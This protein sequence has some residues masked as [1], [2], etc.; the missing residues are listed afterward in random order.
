MKYFLTAVVLCILAVGCA[1][2]SPQNLPKNSLIIRNPTKYVVT[3][4]GSIFAK[5]IVINPHQTL[6]LADCSKLEKEQAELSFIA[7]DSFGKRCAL[8]TPYIGKYSMKVVLGADEPSKVVTLHR[9]R[10]N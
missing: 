7:V 6:S 5:P 4:N 8:I 1:T 2:Q 9:Y 3:A 10:F